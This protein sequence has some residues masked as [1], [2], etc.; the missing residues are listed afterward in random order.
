M[1][2]RSCD[3]VGNY[4]GIVCASV[5]DHFQRT[6]SSRRLY[7]YRR[8]LLSFP[9]QTNKMKTSLVILCVV[10]CMVVYVN[11]QNGTTTVT[12]AAPAMSPM[13][14]SSVAPTNKT[15][16]KTTKSGADSVKSMF[17]VVVPFIYFLVC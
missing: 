1:R 4:C 13:A 8:E 9:Q 10:L 6:P 16:K 11:C 15:T 17:A 3:W 2:R 5:N 14:S 7:S 12:G